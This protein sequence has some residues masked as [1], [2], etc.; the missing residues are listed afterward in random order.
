MHFMNA[1]LSMKQYEKPMAFL[2]LNVVLEDALS[3]NISSNRAK[4][5][6]IVS[7]PKAF[8]VARLATRHHCRWW[9]GGI[10]SIVTAE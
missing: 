7:F 4:T 2:Y 6:E 10:V 1:Q 8:F 9:T 5:M 3:T